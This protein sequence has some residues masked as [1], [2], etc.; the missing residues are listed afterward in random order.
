MRS[1][2]LV[3]VLTVTLLTGLVGCK[4]AK[5]NSPDTQAT[6]TGR[7]H[8]LLTVGTKPEVL[9][10]PFSAYSFTHLGPASR[11]QNKHAYSFNAQAIEPKDL[12]L[13]LEDKLEVLEADILK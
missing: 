1:L 12:V 5:A 6:V 7:V 10:K 9:L 4:T 11:S 2:L 3:T 13:A 8:V